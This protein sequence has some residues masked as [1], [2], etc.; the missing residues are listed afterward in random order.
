M[1][2]RA[3]I[4]TILIPTDGSV[5]ARV[6][7]ARGLELAATAGAAVHVLAVVDESWIGSAV[8][9]DDA[10]SAR[11]ELVAA[12]EEAV[13]TVERMAAELDPDL[14]VTTAVERGSVVDEIVAYTESADVDAIAMGTKGLT[15]LDHVV[16]GS[17]TETVLRT[18]SVPVLAIPPA[19][20]DGSLTTDGVA[21]ILLPT[22][23]SKGAA[24]AVD[25]GIGVADRLDAMVHALFSVDTSRLVS[26]SDPQ[27]VLSHLEREGQDALGVVRNRARDRGCSVTGTVASGPAVDVILAYLDEHDIDLVV[28]GTH[29]RSGLGQHLLGSTTE[30]VVRNAAV[31]LFCVPL[32]NR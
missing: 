3:S 1:T 17:V 29:G 27:D 10:E 13:E 20:R 14:S 11:S 32:P 21:D 24:A 19:A 26:A 4:E 25:W 15:G 8:A 16:L 18:V 9:D 5:G 23:G 12:A 6:G 28:M 31:P 2:P 30:N 22:D 7:A